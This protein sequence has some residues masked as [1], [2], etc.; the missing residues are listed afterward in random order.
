MYDFIEPAINK[1]T[2]GYNCSI[3][4]YGQT[5][6]G[7]TYTMFGPN[8]SGDFSGE[9]E[10]GMIPQAIN[11]IFK[12]VDDL[13]KSKN[14]EFTVYWSFLQIYNEKLYDLLQDNKSEN[15]LKIREDKYAGIFVEGWSEYVITNPNDWLYLLQ[16]G[17]FNR[18]TRQTKSNVAS[19]RSHSL[20]QFWVESVNSSSN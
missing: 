14:K 1:V 12:Q 19:S 9:S 5:G 10:D 17:E 8:F 20:F 15:P 16:R 2:Q 7:K 3:F 18:I 11:Q 4:A 13:E 6:S